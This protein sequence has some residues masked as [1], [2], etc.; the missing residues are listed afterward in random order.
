[1]ELVLII[2]IFLPIVLSAF[3]SLFNPLL[4]T[5]PRAL[6]RGMQGRVS[7]VF[8]FRKN[9]PQQQ[10]PPPRLPCTRETTLSW[11]VSCASH[12][13]RSTA[14]PHSSRKPHREALPGWNQERPRGA[15]FRSQHLTSW[16]LQT[17]PLGR[18]SS[19]QASQPSLQKPFPGVPI[20]AQW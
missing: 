18:R 3:S 16:V 17:G 14:T 7:S 19:I 4:S 6:G 15:V 9:K 12:T 8:T 10:H 11:A 13:A 5:S 1:M 2:F 20:V